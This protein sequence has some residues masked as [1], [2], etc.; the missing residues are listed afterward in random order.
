MKNL[1]SAVTLVCLAV[2]SYSNADVRVLHLSPDA[3]PVD[4]LVG[5]TQDSQAPLLTDFPY[6]EVSPYVPLPTGN[7]FI[8]VV[9][10]AGGASVIDVNGLP[11]DGDTDYS[12]AAVNELSAIEPLVLVDDNTI[13]PSNARIRLVH[14]S[15]NAPEVDISVDGLGV[16]S[17]LDFKENSPYLTLPE[18]EYTVRLLLAGTST[19]VLEVPGLALSAGTVYSAFAA[20]FVGGT[21]DQALTVLP[22]VDAVPEPGSLILVAAGLAMIGLRRRF[23]R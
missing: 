23:A 15:P 3:P 14:A 2:T 5:A 13:D 6:K 9:P 1:V 22:T 11:I 10:S 18:G 8:D 12:I 4:V 19:E 21:G 20:G 7:Y 17:T 16:V